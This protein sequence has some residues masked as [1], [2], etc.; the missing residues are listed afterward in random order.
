MDDPVDVDPAFDPLMVASFFVESEEGREDGE[1]EMK[2]V[3][4]R[5]L[6]R[7]KSEGGREG[8]RVRRTGKRLGMTVGEYMVKVATAAEAEGGEGGG[9]EVE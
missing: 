7:P 5:Y 2:K 1:E 8:G 9:M 3:L 4:S 6:P